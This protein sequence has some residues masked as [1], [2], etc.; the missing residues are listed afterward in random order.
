MAS[1]PAPPPWASTGPVYESLMARSFDEPFTLYGLIAQ[2]I[3]TDA[4]RD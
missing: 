2:S 4:A 1:T 3:E